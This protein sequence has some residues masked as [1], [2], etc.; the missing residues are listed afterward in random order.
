L[1]RH[2]VEQSLCLEFGACTDK[3]GA[4]PACFGYVINRREAPGYNFVCP[5]K[6]DI[7]LDGDMPNLVYIKI[8]ELNRFKD[9]L[10]GGIPV[11]RSFSPHE[12]AR[13]QD[14][15]IDGGGLMLVAIAPA[16]YLHSTVKAKNRL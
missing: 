10:A 6:P 11:A 5:G 16:K 1:K 3:I 14:P 9:I 4:G 8:G 13:K 7:F 2:A 12:L 15:A